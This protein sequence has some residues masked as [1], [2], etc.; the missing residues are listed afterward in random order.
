MR[1]INISAILSK[2][3]KWS[4]LLQYNALR[5]SQMVVSLEGANYSDF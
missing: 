5:S 1:F 4:K 2:V 3:A